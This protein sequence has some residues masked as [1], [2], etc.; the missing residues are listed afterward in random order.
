[1]RSEQREREIM[2][3]KAM[4]FL[5]D[6]FTCIY[7]IPSAA[8]QIKPTG[9]LLS[10]DSVTNTPLNMMFRQIKLRKRQFMSKTLLHY[11]HYVENN[12]GLFVYLCVGGRE[13]GGGGGKNMS[14]VSYCLS[15]TSF[16]SMAIIHLPSAPPRYKM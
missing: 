6:I 2:N 14:M 8:N 7:V 16:S 10:S 5:F 4:H 13:G 15:A 3:V 1:V 11:S 12:Y 9:V